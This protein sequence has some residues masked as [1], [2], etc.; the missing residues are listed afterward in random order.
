[1]NL[2]SPPALLIGGGLF[3]L[4]GHDPRGWLL[5]ALGTIMAMDAYKWAAQNCSRNN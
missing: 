1:M 2:D 3:F 5:I 4:M